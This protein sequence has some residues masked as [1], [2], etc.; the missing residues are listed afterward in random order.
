MCAG[1]AGL[2][3]LRGPWPG[4]V[5]P[6]ARRARGAAAARN[7]TRVLLQLIC[8]VTHT[9]TS[10]PSTEL[11]ATKQELS[12]ALAGN[13]GEAAAAAARCEAAEAARA[14]A[15][16]RWRAAY[17]ELAQTKR[18]LESA[19]WVFGSGVGV[20]GAAGGRGRPSG[21]AAQAA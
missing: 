17:E 2:A 9:G 8:L 20:E 10:P 15:E 18:D 7:S 3:A 12:S 21:R 11:E 14:E 4:R 6:V 1:G 16:A 13:G 5:G 19:Q